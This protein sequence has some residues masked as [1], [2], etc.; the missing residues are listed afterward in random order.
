MEIAETN[1]WVITSQLSILGSDL[2]S[3]CTFDEAITYLYYQKEIQV[4]TET[5]NF[6]PH[7]SLPVC[8]QLGDKSGENQFL[9][10]FEGAETMNKLKPLLERKDI[11]FVLHNAKFDLRFFRHYKVIITNVYDTF[12]AECVL[13]TGMRDEA[14]SDSNLGLEDLTA[15]YLGVYLNKSVRSLINKEGFSSRVIHYSCEDVRYLSK[16][17][18]LQEIKIKEWELENT[19]ELENKAC[20]AYAALE[21]SGIKIDTDKWKEVAKK[22]EKLRLAKELDLDAIVMSDSKLVSFRPRFSQGV[23]FQEYADKREVKINWGSAAQKLK[24]LQALL[25]KE[26]DSTGDRVLQRNKKKHKFVKELIEFNKLNKLANSFGNSM[27]KFVNPVTKRIHC[28]IWQIVSTGRI[29]VKDPNLNQI[30]SK[31]ELAVLIRSCFIA[32]E[33]NSIV[34]GDY[35]GMELRIIA[36]FS[37]DPLWVNSFKEGKDLHSVLCAKTF[38]IQETDVKNPFYLKPEMSYRDV[39]KTI[40]FGLAYGMSEFKLSDTMDIAVRAAKTIIDNF[41]M[42]VPKVQSLLTMFGNAAKKH[43]RIRTAPPFRRVRWF[44]EHEYAVDVQDR[45]ILGEIER[46]GK[47]TPIQG[48][49]GDIIK[50]ALARI[51]TIIDNE[52]LPIK[53]LLSVYD[54][55]RTE[56]PDDMAE[57]WAKRMEKVM[58][59]SAEI[60]IKTV[61]IVVDCKVSKCWEK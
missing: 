14:S 11:V 38:D 51:Q 55:I 46:A 44:P 57:E 12:L 59:E 3:F 54:E 49:N 22:V 34:G 23:L 32:E 16:I 50:V 40:N 30:P 31:G 9:F 47:N 19:I 42:L 28:S 35:S 45:V 15:N 58:K 37:Q 5:Q 43:G 1:R 24:V 7:T 52:N 48:T 25:G 61:P 53:L 29:S 4:D 39:Q 17:K 6:D 2:Y 33:G 13:T 56:C 26:I 27:L 60:V 18:E 10:P 41:F 20:I 36:E 8:I 21:Y